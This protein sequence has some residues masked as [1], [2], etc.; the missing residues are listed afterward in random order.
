MKAVASKRSDDE[1]EN[2]VAGEIPLKV[3]NATR[4]SPDPD[5]SNSSGESNNVNLMIPISKV[6]HTF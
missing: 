1:G 6:T 4:R 5:S 3:T 2:G